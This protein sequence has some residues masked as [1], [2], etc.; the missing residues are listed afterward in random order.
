MDILGE[1]KFP[2]KLDIPEN[3]PFK[4]LP[5][6]SCSAK[7]NIWSIGTSDS[8]WTF[9]HFFFFLRSKWTAATNWPKSSLCPR[10]IRSKTWIGQSSRSRHRRA[11]ETEGSPSSRS[12]NAAK[13]VN[14]T[15]H[16]S[17]PLNEAKITTYWLNTTV[18]L[19]DIY[20]GVH[21]KLIL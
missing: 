20:N 4:A 5:M 15:L 7:L 1:H 17:P 3:D 9:P 14:D 10:F 21:I 19:L 12:P 18:L 2:G 6:Q 13:E 11:G 8:R 16:K